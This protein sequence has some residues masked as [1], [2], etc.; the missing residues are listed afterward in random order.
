MAS[1]S[2]IQRR[3]KPRNR[4]GSHSR[5]LSRGEKRTLPNKGRPVVCP[6]CGNFARYVNGTAIYPDRPDLAHLMFWRCAPCDAHVGTHV[7]SHGIPLGRMADRPLRL[8]RQ[9]THRAF[10]PFW[11]VYGDSRSDAYRWL[12]REMGNDVKACHVSW[13][14]EE[15]C[16]KAISVCRERAVE[17]F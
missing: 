11:K 15:Q 14:D 7:D 12:A 6:Y 8:L 16:R 3:G 1:K 13:F 2:R 4:H 9:A 10:D 17:G 5:P